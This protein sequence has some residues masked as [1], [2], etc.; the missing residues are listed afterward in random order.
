MAE[1][2]VLQLEILQ[3]LV[4]SLVLT[5]LARVVLLLQNA[6]ATGDARR[7]VSGALL[8]RDVELGDQVRALGTVV[9]LLLLRVV[10]R[11][12]REQVYGEQLIRLSLLLVDRVQSLDF[13]S[14]HRD[15]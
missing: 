6:H 15:G 10:R 1:R 14:L 8:T 9:L 13:F 12:S 3:F 2:A 7:V 11:L 5:D 4:Q